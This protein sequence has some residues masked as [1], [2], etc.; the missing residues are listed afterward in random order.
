MRPFAGS[1]KWY[2]KL[3]ILLLSCIQYTI[4]HLLLVI[5]INLNFHFILYS[6]VFK[7]GPSCSWLRKCGSS[8][9][10]LANCLCWTVISF[11]P[12]FYWI[13]KHGIAIGISMTS[14]EVEKLQYFGFRVG[15]LYC[16]LSVSSD[17]VHIR[18]IE[19]LDP[20]N[21]KVSIGIMLV[22]MVY[23][24]SYRDGGVRPDPTWPKPQPK[25]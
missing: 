23:N 2:L 12:L 20:E 21:I 10:W 17:I 19:F 25:Q 4:W 9:F 16:W 8:H 3:G 1:M 24:P 11:V 14:L 6:T 18:I 13:W 5:I 15:I 22:S 7:L